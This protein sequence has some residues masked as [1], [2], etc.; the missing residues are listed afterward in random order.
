MMQNSANIEKHGIDFVRASKIFDAPTLE[1]RDDRRD[2]AEERIIA[3]GQT[4]G[5]TL[6]VVYTW[7][8]QARRIISAWKGGRD[9][10]DIYHQSIKGRD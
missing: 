1:K 6:V 7:R 8:G 10:Q 5:M 2:Y 9:E 4:G 3:L